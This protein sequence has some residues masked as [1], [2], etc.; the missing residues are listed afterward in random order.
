M[1]SSLDLPYWNLL[2]SMYLNLCMSTARSNARG[3][4][5][6]YHEGI[7]GGPDAGETLT[8]IPFPYLNLYTLPPRTKLSPFL[9]FS[10]KS[11]STFPITSPS[12]FT[13][14]AEWSG[15]VPMFVE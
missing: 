3:N 11:S 6:E 4:C 15:M 14:T 7:V 9:S 13:K 8:V 2:S 1:I 10:I 5:S 12:H